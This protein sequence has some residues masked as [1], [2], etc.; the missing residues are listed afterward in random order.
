MHLIREM[1]GIWLLLARTDFTVEHFKSFMDSKSRGPDYTQNV[2][3][4]LNNSF[5]K[6]LTMGFH[7]LSVMDPTMNG[8]QPFEVV[9][10]SRTIY[11]MCNGEIYNYKEL[12]CELLRDHDIVMKSKSDC[13]VLP[14]LYKVYGFD[15]MMSKLN[16]GE[17]AISLIHHDKDTDVY[18]FY[19]G[20]DHVGVRPLYFG[21][22]NDFLCFSSELKG[23]PHIEE[24]YT[25]QFE[26]GKYIH[27]RQGGDHD[28]ISKI[29]KTQMLPYHCYYD[30][31]RFISCD[32]VL[33][34]EIE[35]MKRI[36]EVFTGAVISRLEADIPLGALLSGGLDSSLICAIASKHLR[37]NGKV[38]RTF[39][40][41]MKNST[42]EYYARKVA[43]FIG[44]DHTHI[45]LEE[46]QFI[47]A[48]DDVIYT[49]ESYDTTTVR[50]STGQ[51]LVSK[52][53]CENYDVKVLLIGDG[54]DELCSGYMYFHNAPDP[55]ASH[56]ENIR[57]V[58]D[59]HRYDGQRADRSIS[60]H[61]LEAR[62]PFLDRR[63]IDLYLSIDPKLRVPREH[64]GRRTE[65]YLLRKTFEGYLPDEC[66]WR[67]KEAFSDGVSSLKKSWYEIIQDN[68]DKLF[69]D[70]EF[71]RLSNSY[72]HY[73]P[74]TKEELFFR[75]T[76]EKHY[77]RNVDNVIPYRWVPKWCGTITEP[78][79]RILSVYDQEDNTSDKV[80][81][82]SKIQTTVD[83]IN[84]MDYL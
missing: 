68:A 83:T 64:N 61:G 66:L 49:I 38:L 54:S 21:I 16:V 32:N 6:T 78:S 80:V 3:V 84:V 40:I 57:L 27:F 35:C 44:S 45:V 46:S 25:D 14:Y 55:V 69:T 75:K 82:K 23:I 43:E 70:K 11:A 73:K 24:T 33:T 56:L 51:Y 28:D 4:N 41:G 52:H 59:I 77:S 17:F 22:N 58:K 37:A 31:E 26:P 15:K 1:C 79:A 65:K 81:V 20:R 39:S 13:E 30:I 29:I 10:G 63:F 67:P 7:R 47:N 48:I 19:L 71:E 9:D 18:D 34:D 2:S 62:V 42:D 74:V 8:S 60:G 76:F 72:S 53:I 12:A 50:A 5:L 36:K